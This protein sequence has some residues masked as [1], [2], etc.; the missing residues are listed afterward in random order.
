MG[1]HMTKIA[2]FVG[3]LSSTS[4]NKVL[5][6]KLEGLL[7]QGVEFAYA[8]LNLPLFSQDIE[9]DYPADAQANKDL[10]ES[11]DGVLF[12]TPEYNRSV[13]GVLKNA[14]DWAS[15]PW[16]T[17]SFDGKPAITIGTSVG[18]VA[19]VASQQHLK[20]ILTYLN[21][22]LLGQPEAYLSD[23][24]LYDEEGNFHAKVEEE[25][26]AFLDAFLAHVHANAA[27]PKAVAA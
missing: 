11:A 27:E 22:K 17:N 4:I 9:G 12:V 18:P 16:G 5:A 13:P 24:N 23:Y 3:S 10:V 1:K 2:V 21:T 14:I 6:E 8:N 26:K 15:R 20:N 25:L 7:P 19:T